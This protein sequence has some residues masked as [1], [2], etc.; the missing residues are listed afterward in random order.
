MRPVILAD[1]LVSAQAVL[2][3][4][5]ALLPI[6]VD[7]LIARAD[8]ADRFRRRIGRAHPSW[9]DGTLAAAAEAVPA[10][11]PLALSDPDAAEALAAVLLAIARRRREGLV[12]RGG[13][14]ISGG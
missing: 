2:G 6:M 4:P 13:S 9:G 11:E 14:A 7:R 10:S 1:L 5:P 12:R 3:A 8:A